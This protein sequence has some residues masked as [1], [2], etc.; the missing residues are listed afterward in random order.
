MVQP[1]G[2]AAVASARRSTYCRVGMCLW[3]VQEWWASGHAYPDAITQWNNT[4]QHRDRNIPLGAPVFYS[5]GYHGHI[6]IYVGN[7]MIRSTDAPSNGRVAEVPLDWPSSRW[8]HG[9]IG[10]GSRLGPS[11]LNLSGSAPSGAQVYLS[12][13]HAGQTNS[14]SVG[15]LQDRLNHISFPPHQNIGVTKNYDAATDG[16]VRAWQHFIGDAVDPAGRSSI[17][18]RQAARLWAGTNVT[19]HP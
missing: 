4:S 1:N 19:V 11:S 3:Q 15:A 5:G 18:P 16:A 2:A 14:D 12:T 9:Y 10:W 8:G 6:A 7:G 17:G 13:L